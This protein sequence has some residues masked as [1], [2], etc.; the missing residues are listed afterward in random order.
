[1]ENDMGQQK[2]KAWLLWAPGRQADMGCW[3]TKEHRT[4]AQ[5]KLSS[6]KYMLAHSM[7]RKMTRYSRAGGYLAWVGNSWPSQ[8]TTY[9]MHWNRSLRNAEGCHPW[10]VKIPLDSI[11][12]NAIWFLL[13]PLPEGVWIRVFSLAPQCSSKSILQSRPLKFK[14]LH[15]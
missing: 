10:K 1:M 4:A 14:F 3:R 12:S 5:S 15:Y 7:S 11:L 8:N 6:L 2:S 13:D 9:S